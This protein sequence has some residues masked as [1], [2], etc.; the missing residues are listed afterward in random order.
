MTNE[1]RLKYLKGLLKCELCE[2]TDTRV[3]K[4]CD[5]RRIGSSRK[6]YDA[7]KE[8]IEAL[9]QESIFDKI[10][11]EIEQKCCITVGNENEP[12]I[13]LYDVFQI[14]DKYKTESEDKG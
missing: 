6:C 12:A 5:N 11:A 3:C 7:L 10:R 14:I 2:E 13:T 4:D 9:E 1:D 8:E